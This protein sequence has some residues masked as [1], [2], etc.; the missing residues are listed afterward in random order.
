MSDYGNGSLKETK[1]GSYQYWT[2]RFYDNNG[3]QKA[4]RFPHT[5]QGKRE[6]KK[7]QKEVSK[8]SLTAFLFPHHTQLQAG[9]NISYR[10]T[11]RNCVKIHFQF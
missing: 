4:K 1:V 5:E 7:F 8:R 11:K 3:V 2:V 9:R 10:I 6:A